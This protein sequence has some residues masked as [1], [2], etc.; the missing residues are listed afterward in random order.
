MKPGFSSHEEEQAFKDKEFV[1]IMIER[2]H[3]Q[4][5]AESQKRRP[6]RIYIKH[7]DLEEELEDEN[8]YLYE[9]E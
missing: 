1:R 3:N 9:Y 8:D 6:A 2:Q 5:L 7:L 4:D